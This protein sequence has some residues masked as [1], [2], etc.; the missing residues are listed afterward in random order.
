MQLDGLLQFGYFGLLVA[1]FLAA[2]VLPFSSEAFV[3]VMPSLGYDSWIILCVA[4][5]GNYLGALTNYSL[6]RW[7]ARYI[8]TT[9]VKVRPETQERSRRIFGRWGAPA[10]ILSWVPVIGDPLTFVAGML[11]TN[12]AAFTFWVVL[13]KA[14]RYVVILGIAKSITAF[15]W[16]A[17]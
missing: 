6:G 8:F 11:K 12:L 7:G 4:T 9:I 3:A 1:S 16:A 14:A 5:L 17:P 10:L 2:S 15:F 13:G